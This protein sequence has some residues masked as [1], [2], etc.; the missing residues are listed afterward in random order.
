[1]PKAQRIKDKETDQEIVTAKDGRKMHPNSLKNMQPNDQIW[2]PGE[3]GNPK[4]RPKN[5]ILV[6]KEKLAEVLN[7]EYWGVNGNNEQTVMLILK[8]AIDEYFTCSNPIDKREWY[9]M[10]IG[11]I[12]TESK[13]EQGNS[14][15]IHAQNVILLPPKNPPI[16]APVITGTPQEE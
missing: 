3:S 14:N 12:E 11:S 7:Q 4:G 2:K 9:R 13:K 10:L 16:E 5:P 15:A 6:V 1:M 8:D